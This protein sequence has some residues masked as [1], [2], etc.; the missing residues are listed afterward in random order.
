M[1]LL[2]SVN[3]PAHT[4][5]DR[6]TGL[7]WVARRRG[8]YADALSKGNGVIF[9]GCESTGAL[10][11]ALSLVLKTLG[12]AAVAPG[13][14]D[15]TVYGTSRASPASFY[16]HHAAAISAAVTQADALV[17]LNVASTMS[18]K[19]SIGLPALS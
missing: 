18:F 15:G 16:A 3:E 2:F 1:S 14:H 4:P 6:R 7:G 13:T 19:L 12:R 8:D 5:L 17:V 11:P 9:L 10:F